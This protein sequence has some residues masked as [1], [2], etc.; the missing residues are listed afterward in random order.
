[1]GASMG[2]GLGLDK[3]TLL[4]AALVVGGVVILAV[5]AF[6]LGRRGDER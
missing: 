5:L 3:D 6:G 2:A 1:M 4:A